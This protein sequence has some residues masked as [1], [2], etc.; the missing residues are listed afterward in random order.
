MTSN[1][2]IVACRVLLSEIHQAQM[3]AAVRVAEVQDLIAKDDPRDVKSHTLPVLEQEI[4][5][6]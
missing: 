3:A 4:F 1:E 2:R 6:V 5:S